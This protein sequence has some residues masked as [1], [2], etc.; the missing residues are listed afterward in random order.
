M[1]DVED[2]TVGSMRGASIDGASAVSPVSR[3]TTSTLEYPRSYFSLS[4]MMY[5]F[6][7]AKQHQTVILEIPWLKK[8]HKII[9]KISLLFHD[10]LF[11]PLLDI[12]V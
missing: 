11:K 3:L 12:N 8:W 5:S 9:G 7:K 10:V 2:V 6:P 4:P 1:T